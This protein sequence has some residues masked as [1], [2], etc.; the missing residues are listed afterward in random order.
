MNANVNVGNLLTTIAQ[1]A[2]AAKDNTKSGGG[3][4][5]LVKTTGGEFKAVKFLTH[6]SERGW[7]FDRTI[8]KDSAKSGE[9]GKLF[10]ASETLE[11]TL[12][13]LASRAGGTAKKNVQDLLAAWRKKS[14]YQGKTLL[15]REVVL[16]A[17]K[18]INAELKGNDKV[19]LA[20]IRGADSQ[21]NT[22][23]ETVRDAIDEQDAVATTEYLRTKAA[24]RAKSIGEGEAIKGTRAELKSLLGGPFGKGLADSDKDLL[25]TI[26][27]GAVL[28]DDPT[29][30]GHG[31]MGL[32]ISDGALVP[33]KFLTHYGERGAKSD[34]SIMKEVA[35]KNELGLKDGTSE[36]ELAFASSGL[37]ETVLLKLAAKVGSGTRQDVENLF[38]D[39]RGKSAYE[40]RTLLSRDVVLKAAKLIAEQDDMPDLLDDLG[41]LTAESDTRIERLCSPDVRQNMLALA[42]ELVDTTFEGFF[43]EEWLE[44]FV[45]KIEKHAGFEGW[46]PGEDPKKLV[47]SEIKEYGRRALV[48]YLKSLPKKLL[49]DEIALPKLFNETIITDVSNKTQISI[50]LVVEH[51]VFQ[52]NQFL[53][54]KFMEDRED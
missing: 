38:S 41:P 26:A 5:G 43:T 28:P 6:H 10:D 40:G 18:A 2:V 14:D 51:K 50:F 27:K 54:E 11:R 35:K 1:T 46:K 13:D 48:K 21:R 22:K 30:S 16:N 3:Y 24:D 15:S 44:D 33:Q 45:A 23:L 31:Y 9:N 53:I 8:V 47:K 34:R 49:S 37:L 32:T 7:R 29:K 52:F 25:K 17:V 36:G 19:N 4:M 12:L 39:W 42:D 20:T